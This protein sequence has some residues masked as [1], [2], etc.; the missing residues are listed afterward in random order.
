[1]VSSLLMKNR[2]LYPSE[3]EADSDF[4]VEDYTAVYVGS[5]SEFAAGGVEEGS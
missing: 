2:K 3:Q 1:M 5:D 4:E